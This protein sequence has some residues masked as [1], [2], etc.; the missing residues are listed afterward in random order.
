MNANMVY[1]DINKKHN[2]IACIFLFAER[3]SRMFQERSSQNHYG[4][5]FRSYVKVVTIN[6]V[7][8]SF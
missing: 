1:I 5:D 2:Y 7:E 4:H 8:L 6:A 3:S